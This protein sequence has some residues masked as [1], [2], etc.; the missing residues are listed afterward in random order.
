MQSDLGLLELTGETTRA[1]RWNLGEIENDVVGGVYNSQSLIQ[2]EI[3]LANLHQ[4]NTTVHLENDVVGG[5]E[6]KKLR[7]GS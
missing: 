1:T 4:D 6:R 7:V 5:A 2:V 3:L